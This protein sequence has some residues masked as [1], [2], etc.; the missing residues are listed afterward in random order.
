MS[1]HLVVGAT[2]MVGGEVCRLLAS[3]G[4]HVRA[5]VRPTSNLEKVRALQALGVETVQGDLRNRESLEAACAGVEALVTTASSMP[6]A[7][8]PG[9][10]D[11]RTTDLDG[12]IR[13]IDA[14]RAAKVRHFVYTSISANMNLDFP[15]GNAKRA[16]EQNLMRSG[17][18][19]TILRPSFFMEVWLSPA[20]GF[21][22]G[23]GRVMIYGT[24]HQPV[25]WIAAPDVAHFAV[26]SLENPAAVN[27]VLELGGPANLSPLEVVDVFERTTARTL[28][29]QFVPAEALAERQRG[30]TDPMQQSFAALMRCVAAGDLIDMRATLKA[31][32]LQLTSVEEYAHRL[33]VPA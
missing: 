5:L 24:G 10:N 6:F 16:V 17:M 22:V 21:D 20:V 25:A 33:A 29:R 1:T 14:A 30:A 3:A 32:P 2:G 27:A 12:S 19:Y 31:F 28:E 7:Y 4:K 8:V 18:T 26:A 11:I 13:L 15:T 23:A 9:E